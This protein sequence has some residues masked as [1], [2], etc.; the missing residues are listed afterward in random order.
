MRGPEVTHTNEST[1]IRTFSVSRHVNSR[2]GNISLPLWT[3][4]TY[5]TD[6][7]RKPIGV[8]LQEYLI[9]DDSVQGLVT[10]YVK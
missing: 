8:S 6:D 5:D 9:T 3:K 2:Y 10:A 4:T 1:Y 7:S